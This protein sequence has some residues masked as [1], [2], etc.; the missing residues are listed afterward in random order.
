MT[1]AIVIRPARP[2]DAETAAAFADVKRAE[3][4]RYSPVFWRPAADARAKHQPFLR[5]CIQSDQFAAFAAE[6]DAE[7][8]RAVVGVA[9]AN[10]HGA[11]AP[12]RADPEPTWFVD[13]FFVADSALW[14]TAG[15]A[16]L[17]EI[18]RS[19]ARAGPRGWSWWSPSAM[20]RSARCCAQQATR[21]PPR[22][23][24]ARSR[25][26]PRPPIHPRRRLQRG[27]RRWWRLLRRS[28]IRAAQ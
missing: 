12:F 5:F 21:W 18:Q 23:G 13:D 25:P 9:L 14:P 17:K 26:A 8:G 4:A 22:G 19:P 6:T 2:D 15:L 1:P 24:C 7:T 3:Y 27:S 28:T 20:S 10:R 16:L 11:P